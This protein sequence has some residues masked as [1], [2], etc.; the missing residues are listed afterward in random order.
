MPIEVPRVIKAVKVG[1]KN[2]LERLLVSLGKGHKKWERQGIPDVH[3][4]P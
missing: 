3:M 4:L 1:A 2:P